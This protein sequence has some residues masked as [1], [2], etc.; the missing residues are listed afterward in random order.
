MATRYW[1]T[2]FA[3]L[4]RVSEKLLRLITTD[5]PTE[6]TCAGTSVAGSA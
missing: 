2:G 5:F 6:V 1:R 3:P 4:K